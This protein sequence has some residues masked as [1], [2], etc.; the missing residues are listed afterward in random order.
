M[1]I[2]FDDGG[3]I[4]FS[5][6]NTINKYFIVVAARGNSNEKIVNAAEI[7]KAQLT[8]L[9]N[10][11]DFADNVPGYPEI[12]PKTEKKTGKTN[13]SNK[14]KTSKKSKQKLVE[15]DEKAISTDSEDEK[16]QTFKE[17]K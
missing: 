11:I 6:S 3:Y 16:S 2:N 15:S 13:V 12:K 17:Q 7:D 9:L 4:E 1:R 5:F 8:Q 14:K 10:E